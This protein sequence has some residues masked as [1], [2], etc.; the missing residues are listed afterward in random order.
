MSYM[1]VLSSKT[2]YIQTW[3][4]LSTSP[5]NHSTLLGGNVSGMSWFTPIIS[6]MF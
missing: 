6:L 1:I 2:I 3:T 4:A 5:Y